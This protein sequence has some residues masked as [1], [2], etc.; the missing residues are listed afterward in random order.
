MACQFPRNCDR[1]PARC[2]TPRLEMQPAKPDPESLRQQIESMRPWHH[3]IGITKSLSTGQVFSPTGS[4]LAHENDGVSLISPREGFVDRFKSL[5]PSGLTGKRFLD[6]ACNAGAYCFYARELDAEHTLGFD[7]RKHWIDQAKFVQQH[8]QVGPTD[9]IEFREMDLYDLGKQGLEPF[10][11]TFFSGIFYHLP[12]PITGL[13]LAA[14]LT[15]DVLLLNTAGMAEADNPYGMS[16]I[17]EGVD[18]VMSGVYQLAWFPN[19][20]LVLVEILTWLGFKE[21]KITKNRV[22]DQKR[23]RVEILAAREVGRLKNVKGEFVRS[24]VFSGQ[25]DSALTTEFEDTPTIYQRI[26]ERL[27]RSFR[28]R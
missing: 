10:D 7:V 5:Y 19:S 16:L 21:M 18:P 22:N 1:A 28:K 4:L 3:D 20:P 23:R 25:P 2:S 17:Y 15:Q 12:D 24:R 9:R 27:T 6:C 14:D 13:K 11:F 8:R 26:K